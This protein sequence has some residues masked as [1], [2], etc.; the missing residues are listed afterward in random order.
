MSMYVLTQDRS[1]EFQNKEN[2]NIPGYLDI[3]YI[4][5]YANSKA[6]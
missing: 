5:V 2:G 4:I 3:H 1:L 6:K